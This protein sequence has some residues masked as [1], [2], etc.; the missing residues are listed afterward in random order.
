MTQA[1]QASRAG[2][3]KAILFDN[4]GT[5]VDTEALLLAS[6]RHATRTVLGRVIPDEK[7]MSKVGQPLAVQMPDFTDDE[8][9]QQEL[10][11]V[12]RA[13]NEAAHDSTVRAFD[14]LA[15][16]LAELKRRGY[17]LGVVTSKLHALCERGLH[18]CGIADYFDF[19]VGADDWPEYKP[20]PGPIVH[21]CDVIGFAAA[22]CAYVGDSPFDMQASNGA[23]TMSVA[24]L[25]GMFDAEVLEA[26]HPAALCDAPADLLE[27]FAGC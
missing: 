7:L 6:F 26:E 5:L 19:V 12:Y 11:R 23:G 24:V 18:V 2:Q 9:E 3:V 13:Y 8:A 4:D 25:W 20:N 1:D 15:D 17:A 16:T 14:G 21:G 10:L 22:E 27:I